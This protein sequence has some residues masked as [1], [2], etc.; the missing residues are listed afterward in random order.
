MK[1][2]GASVRQSVDHARGKRSIMMWNDRTKFGHSLKVH[3]W[4]L[5]DYELAANLITGLGIK[6]KLV[7]TSWGYRRVHIFDK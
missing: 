1:T 4:S 6:N 3:G 7:T 5:A 2:I